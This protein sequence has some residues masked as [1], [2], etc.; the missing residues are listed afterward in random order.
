M[1]K[2][3]NGFFKNLPYLCLV[4][5][6]ALGLMSCTGGG[7][8]GTST[9]TADDGGGNGEATSAVDGRVIDTAGNGVESV[10]IVGGGFTSST[11]SDGSF[12]L[13]LDPGMDQIVTFSREGY[14]TS[15]RQVD[16]F[17]G[18]A[19]NLIVTLMAEGDPVTVNN[20]E[21][22]LTVSGLRNAS[23]VAPAGAFV[24]ADGNTATGDVEVY[25]TPFDPAIPEE[26]SAYPGNLRG[27]TLDGDIVTLETF[28][29]MDVTVRQ[30]GQDLQI[31]DGKTV[32]IRIP[33]PSSGQKPDTSDMWTYDVD[34]GLWVQNETGATY[35]S[36]SDTYQAT[37]SHLTPCN[38]DR[39]NVPACI[40]GMV[41]D[42]NGDPVAG[43]FVEAIPIGKRG[44]MTS[45]DFTDLNGYYCLY[46]ERNQELE[47]KV[48][49][50]W[51]T[52]DECTGG[53][54]VDDCCITTI[55]SS[56]ISNTAPGTYPMDCSVD[57]KQ[58][59][60]I[61]VGQDDP[62]PL[63]EAACEAVTATFEDPFTGTCAWGLTDFYECFAPE[64]A[65]E[66]KLDLFS[67]FGPTYEV[68]FEN[69]SRIESKFG[70]FGM[71]TIFYGPDPLNRPCGTMTY[72]A[73]AS[74][75]MI[76]TES[77]RSY[78]IRSLESGGFEIECSGGQT[79][80]L[81]PEQ[82]DFLAGCSA[83][84]GDDDSGVQ[85]EAKEGTFG[86]DCVFDSNCDSGLKCCGPIGGEKTCQIDYFCDFLCED[87]WDCTSPQICCD[88]GGYNI[89]LPAE[90]CQ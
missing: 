65:C 39:P 4:G 53:E 25:L 51:T 9:T 43:A 73:D 3:K 84:T 56:P 74:E 71:E 79:F 80:T 77:G 89:C 13:A 23:I 7:G 30:N 67:I 16:V 45:S 75:T 62:G 36:G 1:R 26:F 46:V 35:D 18:T 83:T 60:S 85:C 28:G 58:I 82:L 78:T 37:I 59:R 66:Y 61:E 32:D 8:G 44:G 70:V 90:A 52:E 42:R 19:T 11:G 48:W 81:S 40:W 10:Q 12:H 55:T 54:H 31:A 22:G 68:E 49:T 33:A 87:D 63:N 76:T 69:G 6:I 57:C 86:A 47:I 88:A 24:D 41:K 21:S 72:S 34:R 50:P 15:S 38:V 17:S 29:V 20:A 27:L 2:V 64:G 14:V 5:V